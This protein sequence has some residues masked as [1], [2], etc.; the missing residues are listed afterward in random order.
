MLLQLL[1]PLFDLIPPRAKPAGSVEVGDIRGVLPSGA[2]ALAK[3]AEKSRDVQPVEDHRVLL[4]VRAS[5]QHRHQRLNSALLD[6]HE[7]QDLG[8]HHDPLR[9]RRFLGRDRFVNLLH[10]QI[11]E[12]PVVG[13]RE[14]EDFARVLVVIMPDAEQPSA[15][16]VQVCLDENV[17]GF[18]ARPLHPLCEGVEELLH[19]AGVHPPEP[20]GVLEEVEVLGEFEPEVNR[21]VAPLL[22]VEEKLH[23][24]EV[25]FTEKLDEAEELG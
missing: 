20:C 9:P 11:I 3:L 6:R 23:R 10:V 2:H 25:P 1:P 7:V 8:L 21:G 16:L 4:P 13:P 24:R 15:E 14:L 22:F 12:L 17:L 18:L 5:F 19:Y